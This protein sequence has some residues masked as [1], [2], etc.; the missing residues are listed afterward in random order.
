[1]ILKNHQ[2]FASPEEALEHHGVKGMHWGVRKEDDS[3]GDRSVSVAPKQVV[4]YN[5]A[6]KEYMALARKDASK[7][8]SKQQ[9]EANLKENA[10][11]F[12]KKFEPQGAI[13]PV[14]KKGLTSN[15]KK[16]LIGGVAAVAVVGGLYAYSKYAGTTPSGIDLKSIR[17]GQKVD[18]ET[19]RSLVGASWGHAFTKTGHVT[20]EAFTR[21]N[22]ELPAGH[23]FYRLSTAA[24]AN[25]G[26]GGKFGDNF[27][28]GTYSSHSIEDF[29]RYVAGFRGEKGKSAESLLHKVEFRSKVPIKVAPV[30]EIL[31]TLRETMSAETKAP[32]SREDALHTYKAM[33]GGGWSLHR[34]TTLL[35]ALKKKG[36]GAI[37]DEMDARVIGQSPLVVF[38]G[39]DHFTAK[40]S[41]PL[42]AE[43]IRAAEN[44]LTEIANRKI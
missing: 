5:E 37:V 26:I 39:D 3:A 7:P 13:P 34:E 33:T 20:D 30:T 6:A 12:S 22:M 9:A 31:E 38:G 21:A 42:G 28:N 4:D 18:G 16:L 2:P 11:K 10:E 36:Y 23:T 14:E 41:T 1:M 17:P 8:V 25:W 27:G 40:K 15:Q 19:Y 32:V 43:G 44:A 29:N 24:E 35:T